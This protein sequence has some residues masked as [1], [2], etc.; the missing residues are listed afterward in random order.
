MGKIKEKFSIH[1]ISMIL[2]IIGIIFIFLEYFDGKKDISEGR[3]YLVISIFSG[4]VALAIGADL[5]IK[6]YSNHVEKVFKSPEFEKKLNTQILIQIENLRSEMTES[7]TATKEQTPADN[8]LVVPTGKSLD[9]I[10]QYNAYACLSSRTFRPTKYISFYA[11]G[12]IP[13]VAEFEKLDNDE[14]KKKHP[15]IYQAYE[16]RFGKMDWTFFIFKEGTKKEINVVHSHPYAFVQNCRYVNY[17]KLINAKT[18]DD[19]K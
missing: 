14:A 9:L 4:G 15:E 7:E 16:E 1:N 6:F 19:L 5:V 3:F 13:L 11:K 17:D 10:Q 12:K 2:I 18:T 8:T